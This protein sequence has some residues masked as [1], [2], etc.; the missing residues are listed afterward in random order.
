MHMLFKKTVDEDR[1]GS[2][3]N[4]VQGQ[5]YTV[6]ECLKMEIKIILRNAKS[7]SCLLKSTAE[8]NHLITQFTE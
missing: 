1:Q 3:T 5:V 2:E 8:A 4:I 7:C 6:I